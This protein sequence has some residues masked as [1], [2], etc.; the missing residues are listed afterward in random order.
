[1]R[2]TML[3]TAGAAALVA[4][5]AAITW[6]IAQ[7]QTLR[8]EQANI[9]M[10]LTMW[11]GVIN[12]ADREA[13]MKYIA[14]DYRQHNPNVAQGRDGVLK[15]I[16]LIKDPPPGMV[17]PGH[18][19]FLRAVAQGDYVVIIWDQPQPDPHNPGQTYTGQAFDMFRVKNGKVIEH[20]DDTR[21]ALRP[22]TRDG[23]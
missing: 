4:T 2:M 1:M 21:K 13:V 9:D 7:R 8:T 6:K 15:L 12:R 14:P 18:K 17:P 20:W 3:L 11:D 19:T 16:S 5:T 23:A 22:W 10:V